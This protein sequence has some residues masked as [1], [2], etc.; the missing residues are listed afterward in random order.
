MHSQETIYIT[1][2]Q[3]T[4]EVRIKPILLE[5][6]AANLPSGVTFRC[7]FC[8]RPEGHGHLALIQIRNNVK[9]GIS[10]IMQQSMNE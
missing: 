4:M 2:T 8:I 9:E 10:A 5:C 6:E 1:S 7:L 3:K